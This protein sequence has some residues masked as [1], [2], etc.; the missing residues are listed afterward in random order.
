MLV[1][2]AYVTCG[3]QAGSKIDID[4]ASRS[5][6]GVS[7]APMSFALLAV[8]SVVGTLALVLL[9]YYLLGRWL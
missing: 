3:L 9:V 7:G 8:V 6:E 1:G 2:M 5:R 4:R